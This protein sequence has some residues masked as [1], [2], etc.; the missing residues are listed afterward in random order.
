VFQGKTTRNKI[1]SYLDSGYIVIPNVHSGRH[2]VLATGYNGDNIM[3]N[4]AYYDTKSYTLDE[5]VEGN[6]GVYSI[7]STPTT[8][9]T[10]L[11]SL[12]QHINGM[13]FSNER[14]GASKIEQ[15]NLTSQ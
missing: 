3:V 14:D 5:I 13:R 11:L 1:K 15:V 9:T 8:L 12:S 4:D 10:W 6:T 2:W 7:T